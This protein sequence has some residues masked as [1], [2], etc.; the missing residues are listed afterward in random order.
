MRPTAAH[1]RPSAPFGHDRGVSGRGGRGGTWRAR[2]RCVA[3]RQAVAS[4]EADQGRPR[5]RSRRRRWLLHVR[6]A[7]PIQFGS[8]AG[9]YSDGPG[10]GCS[11]RE[12]AAWQPARSGASSTAAAITRSAA[13]HQLTE[14]RV[15]DSQRDSRLA[16]R[17][18]WRC[19]LFGGGGGLVRW[20]RVSVPGAG[21]MRSAAALPSSRLPLP[22]RPSSPFS[23]HTPLSPTLH[24]LSSPH[25]VDHV[26]AANALDACAPRPFHRRGHSLPLGS[27]PTTGGRVPEWPPSS[28]L[29]ALVR[30]AAVTS[31]RHSLT[32]ETFDPATRSL[33][34]SMQA[35]T[36]TEHPS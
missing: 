4:A 18:S 20:Q 8:D 10:R 24:P 35:P 23:P 12:C 21:R 32:S 29:T 3:C 17:A 5:A 28:V 19:A 33:P 22:H 11:K 15:S 14:R 31:P 2:S 27:A 7:S 34:P 6:W 13:G 16:V 26:A 1:A 9:E 36:P 25:T 30:L